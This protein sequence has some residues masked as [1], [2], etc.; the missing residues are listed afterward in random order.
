M[1]TLAFLLFGASVTEMPTDLTWDYLI[2]E[3][4]E[5]PMDLMVPWVVGGVLLM[6]LSWPIFYFIC[7]RM[8]DKMRRRYKRYHPKEHAP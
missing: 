4:T 8:V 5:R 1:G 3:L 6:I 2:T 7:Y